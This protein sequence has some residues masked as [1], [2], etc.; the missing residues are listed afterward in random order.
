MSNVRQFVSQGVLLKMRFPEVVPL[1]EN[2]P[3][4][5]ERQSL[6]VHEALFD[7]LHTTN[8]SIV[9]SGSNRFQLPIDRLTCVNIEVDQ[10]GQ[11]PKLISDRHSPRRVQQ[12]RRKR[13][14]NHA[15]KRRSN[16]KLINGMR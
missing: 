13:R 7:W 11:P 1:K 4:T 8:H 10:N 3:L 15:A 6:C 16:A 14:I 12:E 9:F 5:A 2:N